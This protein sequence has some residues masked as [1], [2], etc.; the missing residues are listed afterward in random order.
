RNRAEIKIRCQGGLYIK[1]L[2]T[3]DNGRTN[4]NISS[5][6]KVKAVPKE[7]DVLNVVVEGEKIGEV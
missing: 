5:L 1:E 6:I 2:V 7:L 3:G 4:P